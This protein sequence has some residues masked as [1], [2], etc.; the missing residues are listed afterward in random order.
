MPYY[1]LSNAKR[2]ELI[3]LIAHVAELDRMIEE[4]TAHLAVVAEMGLFLPM[5]D[6]HLERLNESRRR[7]LSELKHLLGSDGGDNEDTGRSR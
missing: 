3:T 4:Q 7:N 5:S 6:V 1:G 2:A